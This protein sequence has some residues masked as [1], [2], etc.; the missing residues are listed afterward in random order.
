[1]RERPGTTVRDVVRPPARTIRET[2]TVTA[3]EVRTVTVTQAE[4]VTV[5][6]TVTC[7]PKEC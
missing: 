3:R 7:K 4:T 1:V 5:V 2:H 6:E